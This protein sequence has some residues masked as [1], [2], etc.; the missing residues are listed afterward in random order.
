MHDLVI[1]GGTVADGSGTAPTA[2]DVAIDDGR[3]TLV[4]KVDAGGEREID[5]TGRLVTPGFVDVHT[6]YDGQVT[7][8]PLLTP[9]SWHGVTTVVMGNCGVGFAPAKP[10]E[11]DWLIGLME[12]VEDIPGAALSEGIRWGWETFPEFLDFLDA[13]PLAIDVATQVPH[14]S[15]RG[16]VMGERGA[17][18]EPATADDIAAMAA[19]VKEGIEAGALGLSTSRTIAHRAIDGE[20]VPGT[21][22]AED[23]LFGLGRMLGEV[24]QGVFELAPAGVMGEDLAAPEREMEWMRRL[25]EATGR[26]VTFA[27]AQHD[28]SPDQWKAQLELAQQAWDDGI[29]IRPQVAGRPLGLLLG[30][31][32]FHPLNGRPSYQAIADLP[33]DERVERMRDPEVR[34]AILGERPV[35]DPRAAFIGMG[36]DRTFVM[37]DPPDYEPAPDT[38]IAALAADLDADPWDLLYDLLLRDDGRELLLRPLLGY[39]NFDHEAIR[40]MIL[41]PTSALGLGDGGAHVGAICDASIETTMLTHW[42]RDR[43]RGERLPVELV[44]QKMTSDTASLYGLGDRGRLAPGYRA[45]VNVIDFDGLRLHRPEM[46]YDLPGG[47]R[48]LL[49][50]ADGYTSTIVAGVE[51]MRAG[52]ETGARPGG[53]VRG[54]R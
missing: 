40:E 47:A 34:A 25:A 7:W 36:L 27:L 5:A 10:D 6:H 26:P 12:G 2:A 38:S 52:V 44:V 1:R 37:G 15:V 11:H 42:A 51:V 13:Q 3:V 43:A 41:H 33:L 20:P 49:Q 50:R 9:S 48:R 29:Q 54:A 18:N 35:D 19:I 39:S 32:T 24:G 8:D 14:G 16:Y 28:E 22:A 4:G 46:V 23:E 21:F 30:L 53:L 45:D 31:Q 17:R